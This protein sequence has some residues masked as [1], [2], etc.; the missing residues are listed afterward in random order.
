MLMGWHPHQVSRQVVQDHPI[1]FSAANFF[2]KVESYTLA[3]AF[4]RYRQ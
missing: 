4:G 2:A 1:V 3:N